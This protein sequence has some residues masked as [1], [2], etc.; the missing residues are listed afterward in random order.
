MNT[1]DNDTV[2]STATIDL[3]H[4][5][6][7]WCERRA[8]GVVVHVDH[9]PHL[10]EWQVIEL[11]AGEAEAITFRNPYPIWDGELRVTENKGQT[12]PA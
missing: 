2:R 9:P 8:R 11:L 1:L 12:P 3:F 4:Q 6:T 10:L 7:S 5:T